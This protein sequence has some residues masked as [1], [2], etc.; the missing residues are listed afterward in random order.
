MSA[1]TPS[2]VGQPGQDSRPLTNSERQRLYRERHISAKF[3]RSP[4]TNSERQR[5]YRERQAVTKSVTEAVNLDLFAE[6]PVV[7]VT[8][9]VTPA[10]TPYTLAQLLDWGLEFDVSL[11]ARFP[12]E[13]SILPF[14]S[15]YARPDYRDIRQWLL[16]PDARRFLLGELFVLVAKDSQP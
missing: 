14:A 13:I 6:N 16:T 4:L 9:S 10:V 3:D 8:K 5:L 1:V 11:D 15:V 2:Q 7:V 12:L